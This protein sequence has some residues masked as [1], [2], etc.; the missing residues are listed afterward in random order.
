M[1]SLSNLLSSNLHRPEHDVNLLIY[2]MNIQQLVNQTLSSER[3]S[4]DWNEGWRQLFVLA[5][6]ESRKIAHRTRNSVFKRDID[7]DMI[8]DSWVL[9]H[10][11]FT[12]HCNPND[13]A[14]CDDMSCLQALSRQQ[15]E[16]IAD[17]YRLWYKLSHDTNVPQHAVDRAYKMLK[18]ELATSIS[19]VNYETYEQL[20]ESAM[21][22]PIDSIDET[23]EFVRLKDYHRSFK[24]DPEC[25]PDD[26]LYVGDTTR[27]NRGK[28]RGSKGVLNGLYEDTLPEPS[29]RTKE[30]R[31]TLIKALLSSDN[32]DDIRL[33]Y[34][35]SIPRRKPSDTDDQHL[36]RVM[37]RRR[38][39]ERLVSTRSS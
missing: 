39:C 19:S 3:Y 18:E 13:D 31:I 6:A 27:L 2:I 25:D 14:Q 29:Y 23:E 16:Y 32:A 7:P 17:L 9:E 30:K 5:K 4:D 37:K 33:A 36:A 20:H 24:Q 8:V 11:L 28:P 26:S 12:D 34:S 21:P 1:L 35:M 10:E 38:E 22:D 15:D